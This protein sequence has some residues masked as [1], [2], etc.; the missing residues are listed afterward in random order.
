ML[1]GRCSRWRYFL[2]SFP[3]VV[4]GAQCVVPPPSRERSE[5]KNEITYGW[6]A[7]GGGKYSVP[8]VVG[9]M[10]RDCASTEYGVHG[11]SGSHGR[12]GRYSVGGEWKGRRG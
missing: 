3:V 10:Y 6:E 12:R 5:K 8:R 7:V 11:F 9:A 1:R 2:I 4:R